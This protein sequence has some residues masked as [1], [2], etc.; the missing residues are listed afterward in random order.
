MLP[1]THAILDRY[2]IADRYTILDESMIA[3]IA[4][5]ADDDVLLNMSERPDASAIA[6]LIGFD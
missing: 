2:V 6:D 3:D 4:V 1:K 5:G